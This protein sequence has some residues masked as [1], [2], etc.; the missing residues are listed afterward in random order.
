MAQGMPFMQ[1]AAQGMQSHTPFPAQAMPFH[2]PSSMHANP[3]P[4]N[5]PFHVPFAAQKVIKAERK[6]DMDVVV[7][8]VVVKEEPMG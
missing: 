2:M 6:D 7:V 1:F 5:M 4:F 8:V 3:N